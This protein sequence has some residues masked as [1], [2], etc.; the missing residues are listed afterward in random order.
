MSD[1]TLETVRK[2]RPLARAG[3]R[4]ARS[5]GYGLIPVLLVLICWEITTRLELFPPI[6]FPPI[7]SVLGAL[8]DMTVNGTLLA[9][10]AGT[11]R[12]L[13][14]SVVFGSIIGV[15]LGSA[16]GYFSVVEKIVAPSLNFLLSIPGTAFFPLTMMWFGLNETA[17]LVILVYEVVLTTALSTWSGVK[18]IDPAVLNAG[19]SLGAKGHSLFLRVL[20]PAALPSIITG[21]RLAFAR[22]WR[23]LIIAEMLVSLGSGLGYRLY[24]AREMFLSE[25]LYAGL[26]VVG[27]V[28]LLVERLFL[29]PLEIMTVQRWGT[30]RD[31]D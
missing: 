13:V 16:M 6:I 30:L 12:R 11:F 25:Q 8:V 18:M 17:I 24:W 10:V 7:S 21:F 22:A 4:S 20:V 14:I 28:G 2:S 1:S 3:L 29:R 19:R 26:L 5:V 27:L 31:L 9:D 23:I 15:A